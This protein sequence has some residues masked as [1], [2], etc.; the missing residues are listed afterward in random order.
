M[1]M[2]LCYLHSDVS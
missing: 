1:P 2:L